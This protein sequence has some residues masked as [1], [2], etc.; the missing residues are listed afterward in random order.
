M[1][2]VAEELYK[3][4]FRDTGRP[5]TSGDAAEG[6]SIATR[7]LRE[8]GVPLFHWVSQFVHRFDA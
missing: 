4:L 7:R 6:L 3:Y 5:P 2:L 8:M 1:V